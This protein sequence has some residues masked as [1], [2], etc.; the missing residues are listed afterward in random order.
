MNHKFERSLQNLTM[1]AVTMVIIGHRY[2]TNFVRNKISRWSDMIT[3]NL[4]RAGINVIL[5]VLDIED[6]IEELC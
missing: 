1:Q 4:A 3:M 6:H 5:N 2:Y